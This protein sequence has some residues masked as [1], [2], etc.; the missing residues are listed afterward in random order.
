MTYNDTNRGTI[1]TWDGVQLQYTQ[2][3]PSSSPT[4]LFISGTNYHVTTYDHRGHGDSDTSTDGYRV[5]R[6]ASDLNDLING[7]DLKD[8]TLVGHSMGCSVIWAYWS[9]FTDSRLKVNKVVLVDQAAG[10]TA[11]P[12][13]S[14][15]CANSISAI[16]KP[17]TAHDVAAG[18]R[19]PASLDVLTGI[20]RSMFTSA[21]S[22]EDLQW[23][24]QQNLEMRSEDAATLLIEH[25]SNDWRD[26]LPTINIPTLVIG[27]DK[28]LITT[29]GTRFIGR[30]IPNAKV[31]I[32]TEAEK[33]SH[34]MYWENP[35]LFNKVVEEFLQ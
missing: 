35:E 31:R 21:I 2:S 12:G 15:E 11:E 19:S 8:V 1:K 6:L 4:L 16:W 20:L 10:M 23:V 14:E 18:L 30:E 24:L 9:L 7:L 25:A 27:G 32:F 13:W 17:S 29:E 3:G 5:V 26:V 28:S 33:G 22:E 34:F